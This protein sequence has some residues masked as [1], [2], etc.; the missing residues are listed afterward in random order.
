MAEHELELA[1]IETSR[2]FLDLRDE[3][4]ALCE[5]TESSHFFHSFTWCSQIWHSVASVR[6]RKLHLVV[7]RLCGRLV[8]V[9][10]LMVDGRVLRMLSSDTLEYRDVIVEDDVRSEAWVRAAWQM[11]KCTPGVD[12][13]LFQNLRAPSNLDRLLRQNSD[14]LPVGGGW[15]LVIHLDRYAG[16]DLYAKR[17]PK[18]M[19]SDQRRQWARAREVLPGLAFEVLKGEGKIAATLEWIMD[20]KLEWLREKGKNDEQFRAPEIRSFFHDASR[21]ARRHGNLLCARLGDTTT[22]ISAGFGYQFRDQFLFHVFAYDM[23]FSRLSPSR[24]FLE[25]LVRW[26]LENGT[27]TFDFMP[28][29]E[30]YKTVWADD[31]VRTDSYTGPLTRWGELLL[32]WHT[33]VRKRMRLLRPIKMAY[34]R[35]PPTLRR[36]LRKQLTKYGFLGVELE[37]RSAL[38]QISAA[39]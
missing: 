10:P 17:L 5:R 12:L 23:G 7:G 2:E 1:V 8:L 29:D 16:W 32:H 15:C 38:P 3:W 21:A 30:P 26:C 36:N 14:A 18:S 25:C 27:A 28:G 4:K 9:W 13:F 24:L 11:V 37:P 6:G 31:Y 33:T 22:T 39:R 35:L 20:R 19:I 34:A